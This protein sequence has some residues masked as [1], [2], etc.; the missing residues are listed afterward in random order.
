MFMKV[1]LRILGMVINLSFSSS[2]SPVYIRYA[3]NINGIIIVIYK[4]TKH[5]S[6]PVSRTV[7]M[8]L[9]IL[10]SRCQL[11]KIK[12]DNQLTLIIFMCN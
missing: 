9:N 10:L 6:F 12:I 4:K 2:E 8:Y 7:N 11:I 1:I 3:Y 5:H